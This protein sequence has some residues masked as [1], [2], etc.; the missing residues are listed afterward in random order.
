MKVGKP[1]GPDEL[2]INLIPL[3]DV[4]FCLILFLVLTTSF[5]QRAAL[6]LQ[7]PQ[8]Q[9]GVVPDAGTPLIILVDVEG[10]YFIGNNEVLRTDVGS[11]KEAIVRV[12]GDDRSQPVILRADS[13]TPHQSVV[14]AMDALGQLGFVKLS[15]ATTPESRP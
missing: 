9:A 1:Q 10:K 14:T 4:L 11:L 7:L 12:A 5:N 15:I 6:K 2:E 13:R 3:I 8:A